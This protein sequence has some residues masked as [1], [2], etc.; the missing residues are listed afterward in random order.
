MF[1]VIKHM[2]TC[3]K[4]LEGGGGNKCVAGLIWFNCRT[5]EW[6]SL[7]SIFSHGPKQEAQMPNSTWLL[8]LFL[9]ILQS[10]PTSTAEEAT[11]RQIERDRERERFVCV[12]ACE[13]VLRRV[14]IET[15]SD[16]PFPPAPVPA[17]SRP[18]PT[19]PCALRVQ[20]TIK[21]KS[22]KSWVRNQLPAQRCTRSSWW[23]A[24]ALANPPSHCSSC[25]MNLWRITSPPRPIVIGKR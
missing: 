6:L 21:N 13:R 3:G 17:L 15:L 11:D 7:S 14:P 5:V 22:Q 24:V 16:L 8:T 20:Q 25:T 19:H 9:F 23:A 1:C 4:G 18:S 10:L 12:R 2:A